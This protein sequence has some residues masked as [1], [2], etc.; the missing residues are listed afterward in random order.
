MRTFVEDRQIEYLQG[1]KVPFVTI[2]F[3]QVIQV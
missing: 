3:L 1:K 2:G